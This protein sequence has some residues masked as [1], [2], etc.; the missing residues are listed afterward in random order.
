MA[1]YTVFL[2]A[3][4]STYQYLEEMNDHAFVYVYRDTYLAEASIGYSVIIGIW[5]VALANACQCM[6][7]AGAVSSYYFTRYVI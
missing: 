6:I 3:L 5:I 7:V 1:A 4:I 2:G